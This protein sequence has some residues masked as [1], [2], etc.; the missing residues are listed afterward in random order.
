MQRAA[1][2]AHLQPLLAEAGAR[3]SDVLRDTAVTI[4]D[5]R[6]DAYIPYADYIEI[7]DRAAEITGYVDF[8]LR[9]GKRQNLSALGPLGR[10][11][12]HAATLG[13]ALADFVTF[14]IGNS[15]GGSVYLHRCGDD[16]SF[17]YGLYDP[18]A[19]P[20]NQMNDLILATGCNFVREL[21]AGELEPSEIH[22]IRREPENLAPYRALADCPIRFGQ[23]ETCLILSGPSMAFRLNS[24]DMAAREKILSE[25]HGKLRQSSSGMTPRLRH[26]MRSFLLTGATSMSEA[27]AQLGL[28]PRSLRRTLASEG[29]TFEAIKDE[30][31]FTVARELLSLT[32]LPVAEVG[33]SVGYGAPSSF[34]HAFQRWSGISPTRWRQQYRDSYSRG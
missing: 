10:L 25:L 29:T 19:R 20:S 13:E 34:I 24:A 4:E 28:H 17:G 14:Q 15:T 22:A 12:S 27:A 8:G 1:S 3:L 23:S 6:P 7:L 30:V 5:I 2:L 32:H 21:T 16:F 18:D 33:M 11:M 26:A 9:L 31:R